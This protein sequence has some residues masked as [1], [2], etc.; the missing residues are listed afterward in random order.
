MSKENDAFDKMKQLKEL[1]ALDIETFHT[2]VGYLEGK[3][4]TIADA[5]FGD[6]EQRNAAKDLIKRMFRDQRN[7]VDNIVYGELGE[8]SSYDFSA[9]E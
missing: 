1:H 6:I 7:H 9:K 4:L 2:Q 5:A 8:E 3:I